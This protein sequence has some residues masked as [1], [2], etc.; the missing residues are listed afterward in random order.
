MGDGY[1]ALEEDKNGL[2]VPM[3]DAQI[4]RDMA[5]GAAAYRFARRRGKKQKWSI[6]YYWTN[7]PEE[8]G[9]NLIIEEAVTDEASMVLRPADL[10]TYTDEVSAARQ[11]AATA[12]MLT[13]EQRLAFQLGQEWFA[14]HHLRGEG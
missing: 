5:A 10:R 11:R 1:I 3:L 8:D 6:A 4:D 7:I 13:P 2:L 9:L 14:L 12:S